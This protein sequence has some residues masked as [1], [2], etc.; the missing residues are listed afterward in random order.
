MSRTNAGYTNTALGHGE[1]HPKWTKHFS[2]RCTQCFQCT[3]NLISNRLYFVLKRIFI[4]IYFS[5]IVGQLVQIFSTGW[6]N[7]T[8]ILRLHFS[9]GSVL[10]TWEI[11]ELV[12]IFLYL[13]NLQ[14]LWIIFYIQVDL[15]FLCNLSCIFYININ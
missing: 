5:Y 4:T 7:I 8:F 3:T 1:L 6:K 2:T 13:K 15:L 10:R 11:Q 9:G 14:K 12:A